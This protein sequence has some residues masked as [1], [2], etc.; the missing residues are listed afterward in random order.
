MFSTRYALPAIWL[1]WL[2]VAALGANILFGMSV[3]DMP[4]SPL[5]LKL[6]AWHKWAGISLLALVTL[7]L[8][9]R[10]I[11]TPPPPI[12]APVWQLRTAALVHGTL[13]VLMFAIP[14]SGWLVTSAAGIPVIYFGIWELPQLMPKNPAL[15]DSLKAL[16]K[17][18]NLTLLAL[19]TLHGAAALKHHFID[20]DRTLVRMLPFLEKRN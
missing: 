3:A 17:T 10:L 2:M 12:P 7:R 8:S 6:L 13:Y 19:V 15:L 16:H 14:L 4:L 9:L 20:R 1:H 18:L 11:Y 5:K